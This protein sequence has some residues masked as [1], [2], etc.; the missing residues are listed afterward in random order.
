LSKQTFASVGYDL[1]QIVNEVEPD[2]KRISDVDAFARSHPTKWS[3]KEILG[4]LVDSAS[5]NHQRFVRGVEGKGGAFP[6]YNQ[7]LLVKLQ[8]TNE[9]EWPVLIALWWSYNRFLA[10]VLS[11]F[12]AEAAEYS[13][14][15]GDG[16][17]VTLLFIASDYVEHLK[18]HINQIIGRRYSTTYGA[19]A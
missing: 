18:H 16:K 3:K 1:W 4:H 6:G 17:P 14:T 19:K 13:C 12:P 15:I 8:H 2:L 9:V 7:D 11:M 5:N 10:H